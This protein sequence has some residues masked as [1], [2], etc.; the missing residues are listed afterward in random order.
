MAAVDRPTFTFID[1]HDDDLS[2][3]RIKDAGARKAIRSHVMRDVRRRER[4]AGLKRVSKREARPEQLQPCRQ[5][6]SGSPHE[7]RL[8]LRTTASPSSSSSS[9][10]DTDPG[11]DAIPPIPEALLPKEQI[12]L[13]RGPS[14]ASV[15]SSQESDLD[16]DAVKRKQRHRRPQSF[17]AD[18]PSVS[19]PAWLTNSFSPLSSTLEIPPTVARLIHHCKFHVCDVPD[20]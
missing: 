19:N 10:R 18:R 16:G 5:P 1:G 11:C 2:S 12:W 3:K 4:L 13:S 20:S 15:N 7:Q 14:P 9:S 8:V 17:I 6:T